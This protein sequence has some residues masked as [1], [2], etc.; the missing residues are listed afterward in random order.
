MKINWRDAMPVMFG[1]YGP[2]PS[3]E[4]A[5]EDGFKTGMAWDANYTPGGPWICKE[6]YSQDIAWRNFCDQT[7]L[8]NSEWLRGWRD[9]CA[10]MEKKS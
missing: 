3:A 10:H 6:S 2:L 9:G 4:E 7:K 8:N 5:Y 1:K